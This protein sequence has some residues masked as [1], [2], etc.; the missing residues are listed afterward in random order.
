MCIAI[1][2]KITSI[3]GTKAKVDFKGN[4]VDV[5]IGLIEPQIGDYVLVH[6]GCALEIMK[7]EQAEELL[8]IFEELEELG[9]E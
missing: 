8:A 2:G 4:S 6:A 1:P 7:K 5:H 3:D 9:Q